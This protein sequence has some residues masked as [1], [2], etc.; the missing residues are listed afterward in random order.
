[1]IGIIQVTERKEI[2]DPIRFRLTELFKQLHREYF[3]PERSGILTQVRA[4]PWFTE[5]RTTYQSAEY[6]SIDALVIFTN[7]CIEIVIGPMGTR[8]D[9]DRF[10]NIIHQGSGG[11]KPIKRGLHGRRRGAIFNI[12]KIVMHM[13]IEVITSNST[14]HTNTLKRRFHKDICALELDFFIVPHTGLFIGDFPKDFGPEA[15][16]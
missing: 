4:C 7:K 15:I 1:M 6:A 16:K 2:P 11:D 3:R 12:N 8:D 5:Y 14:T 13:H 10:L 9:F